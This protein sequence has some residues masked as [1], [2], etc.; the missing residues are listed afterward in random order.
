[1]RPRV[2]KTIVN[3][4]RARAETIDRRSQDKAASLQREAARTH[5]EIL[6]SINQEKTTLEKKIDE[7]RTFERD[8]RTRLTTYLQS[9]LQ[10]LNEHGPAAPADPMHTQQDLVSS[11]SGAPR[12]PP[13]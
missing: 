9:Q 13:R 10:Q 12:N 7:L 3:D 4:A 1:V 8:Y 11:G 5:T 6:G 2:A